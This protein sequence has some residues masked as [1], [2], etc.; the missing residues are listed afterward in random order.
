MKRRNRTE[1]Q[2][3]WDRSYYGM[4]F[5]G[6]K[7]LLVLLSLATAM[8]VFC[9]V[10]ALL[11]KTGT[12]TAE[13]T[14]RAWTVTYP[15]G[16]VLQ[17]SRESIPF[18][19]PAPDGRTLALVSAGAGIL[20]QNVPW[21]AI[22]GLMLR[23]LMRIRDGHS[24][25]L[26]GTDGCIRAAGW[27]LLGKGIFGT[28]LWQVSVSLIAFQRLYFCNPFDLGEIF[29]GILLLFLADIFRKGCLLQQESD[30]TL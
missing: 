1:K 21:L 22:A 8:T 7:I 28:L 24:P 3:G 23:L 4:V 29:A 18:A 10:Y 25:F 27:V 5:T 11:C 14:G 30:E 9:F 16:S 17:V 2:S 12:L 26:P 20:T 6:V 19:M 13:D 15:F